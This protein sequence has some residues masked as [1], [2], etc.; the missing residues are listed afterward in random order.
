MPGVLKTTACG[1]SILRNISPH[2]KNHT[3]VYT[4]QLLR[5]HTS[6]IPCTDETNH[7]D[8]ARLVTF[9]LTKFLRAMTKFLCDV[10]TLD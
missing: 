5:L 8:I 1:S 2:C 7:L 6:T 3:Q 9:N 4:N 10:A